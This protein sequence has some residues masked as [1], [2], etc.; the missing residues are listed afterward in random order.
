[1]GLCMMLCGED[2]MKHGPIPGPTLRVR[3]KVMYDAVLL[4]NSSKFLFACGEPGIRQSTP[5]VQRV[6]SYDALSMN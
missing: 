6:E 5:A 1:M 3:M 2:Y 4:F